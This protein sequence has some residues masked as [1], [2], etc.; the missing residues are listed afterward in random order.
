[1]VVN[2]LPLFDL[3]TSTH[4]VQQLILSIFRTFGTIGNSIF[5]ACSAWFLIGSNKT[6][7]RKVFNM[8][9]EIWIISVISL[10]ITYVL[11][12]GNLN[13]GEIIKSFFPTTFSLNWYLTYY[14]LFY[15][16]HAFINKGI[17]GL[18]Q[19][20]LLRL[21]TVLF[22]LY[23]VIHFF[24]SD[25]FFAPNAC[26]LL[27]IYFVVAYMKLYCKEFNK[28][29][30]KNLILLFI[31]IAGQIG[32]M[33][34]TNIAGNHFSMFSSKLSHWMINVSPFVILIAVSS[35]NFAKEFKFKNKTINY[36]SSLSLLVYIIHENY[37]ARR[38]FRPFVMLKIYER[39]GYDY[40]VFWVL[41]FAIVLFLVTLI[42]ASTYTLIL[43]KPVTFISNKIYDL[44]IKP[45]LKFE[46]ILLKIK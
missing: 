36:I 33:I 15:L 6:N 45:V 41:A 19:R 42:I 34:I 32:G 28:N 29:K 10:I 40:I 25:L 8:I 21:T 12:H 23:S 24:K 9:T 44:L 17:Y 27:V 26:Y 46:N 4:N 39:F 16:I 20:Q 38:Y 7:K 14:I 1:M 35:L 43:K 3:D 13:Y 5:F 2:A 22:L 31:G 11:R 37:F 18:T 30:K